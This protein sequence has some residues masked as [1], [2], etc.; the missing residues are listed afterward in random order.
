MPYSLTNIKHL[1]HLNVSHNSLSG[2]IG[3]IFTALINLKEM[4][5]SSDNFTGYLPSS[6][7]SLKNLTRLFF[8]SN[9]CTGSVIFLSNFSLSDLDIQDN[10]FS[11]VIPETFQSIENLRIGEN[12]FHREENF[13]P[14]FFPLDT[15]PNI[16]SPP[17]T[18]STAVESYPSHYAHKHKKKGLGPGGNASI[19][20]GFTLLAAC[21]A[22]YAVARFQQRGRRLRRLQ[23]SHSSWQFLPVSTAKDFSSTAPEDSSEVLA[24]SSPPMIDPKY[25]PPLRTRT[26][27]K[28]RRSFSRKSRIPIG[29]LGSVYKAEFHGGQIFAVKNV[30][31]VALAL[32]EEEKFLDLIRNVAPLRHPNIVKLVGYCVEHRQHI[33]VYEHV[34]HLSLDDAL[35]CDS[36]MPLSWG[37]L[38]RV[39]LRVA[40]ALNY[41]HTTCMPPVAHSNL[42][43]ANILLDEDLMPHICDTGLAV[44]KPLTSNKIKIKASEMDI[45]D[46]GYIAPEHIQSGIGNMKDDVNAFGVLLLELLTGRRPFDSSKPR[47]EQSLVNWASS[48]LHDNESLEQ[49]VDAAIKRTIPSKAPSRFADIIS[50]CIQP[51]KEFRPPMTEIQEA[52]I[53]I[54][55]EH[56]ILRGYSAANDSEGPLDR[57]FCSSNS[58][59][60]ASPTVPFTSSGVTQRR[61]HEYMKPAGAKIGVIDFGYKGKPSDI[62]MQSFESNHTIEGVYPDAQLYTYVLGCGGCGSS[63]KPTTDAIEQVQKDGVKVISMS[64][65][66]AIK[67]FRNMDHP[68]SHMVGMKMLEASKNPRLSISAM[69]QWTPKRPGQTVSSPIHLFHRSA[70]DKSLW[71]EEEKKKYVMQFEYSTS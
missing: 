11:G 30:N 34:R 14:W 13:P 53:C 9:G 51:R 16:T 68:K 62:D 26:V 38:L 23:G 21:E 47:A 42:K 24:I 19:V 10:H 25:L 44:L 58:S 52:L 20:G 2:P 40:R 71:Y 70:L 37:L 4:D 8:E 31:T 43:A 39:A 3:D 17:S 18:E 22:F 7:G 55:Q 50:L 61:V 27:R 59:S 67:L 46:T 5:L 65:G 63:P 66:S 15:M 64:V 33:L 29:S 36:C 6:F 60:F 57:S 56:H 28:S 54:L 1:R 41:L 49:M 12:K 48:Q 32:H 45:G 69:I 35:H